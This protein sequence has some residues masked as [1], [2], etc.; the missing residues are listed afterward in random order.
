MLPHASRRAA[1]PSAAAERIR[2]GQRAADLEMN[3]K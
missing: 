2:L 3:D 1:F